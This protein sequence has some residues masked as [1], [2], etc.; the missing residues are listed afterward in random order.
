MSKPW[1]A[2]L[3][4]ALILSAGAAANAAPEAVL[5]ASFDS[6]V[7][8]KG[9]AYAKTH[10]SRAGVAAGVVGQAARLAEKSQL[11]FGLAKGVSLPSG[12]L[13]CWVRPMRDVVYG[14]KFD[15]TLVSI[16]VKKRRRGLILYVNNGRGVSARLARVSVSAPIRLCAGEW[17]AGEWH[18]VALAWTP[19][20]LKLYFDGRLIRE[21]R[22]AVAGLAAPTHLYVGSRGRSPGSRGSEQAIADLDEFAMF[23]KALSHDEIATMADAPLRKGL[24][25]ALDRIRASKADPNAPIV[26]AERSSAVIV[27]PFPPNATAQLGAKELA[28]HLTLATGVKIPLYTE[29]GLA[30]M[31]EAPA[32]LLM[33]GLGRAAREFGASTKGIKPE[34][35]RV[36]T[37]GPHLLLYG[38]DGRG[39]PLAPYTPCGTLHAVYHYL[40]HELGVRWL[41]PGKLG[42]V[43]PRR[44]S[45]AWKKLDVYGRMPFVHRLFRVNLRKR[46]FKEKYRETVLWMRRNHMGLQYRFHY[47]HAFTRWYDKY[48]KDHPEWFARWPDGTTHR[49]G[50]GKSRVKFCTNNEGYIRKMIADADAYFCANPERNS[51]SVCPNDGSSGYCTCAKCTALDI[52]G[53]KTMLKGRIEVVCLADRYA[54]FWNRVARAVAK[55]HPGK[56]IFTYSYNRYNRAPVRTRLE[57]NIVVGF[58]GYG[59]DH[60]E[61]RQTDRGEFVAWAKAGARMW[62]RPNFP[63]SDYFG[64]PFVAARKMAADVKLS[65]ESRMIGIDYAGMSFHW[66]PRAL[67]NYTMARVAWEPKRPFDD[68]LA[69]FTGSAYGPAAPAAKK[70]F[71]ELERASDRVAGPRKTDPHGYRNRLLAQRAYIQG[72]P[73]AVF[74]RALAHLGE[75]EKLLPPGK[76]PERERLNFLRETVNLGRIQ[77]ATLKLGRSLYE[78]GRG[79]NPFIKTLTQRLEFDERHKNDRLISP[80]DLP[81]GVVRPWKIRDAKRYLR[82]VPAAWQRKEHQTYAVPA[83]PFEKDAFTLL[84]LHFDSDLAGLPKETPALKVPAAPNAPSIEPAGRFGSALKLDGDNKDGNGDRKGDADYVQIAN[85]IDT[86]I[87][88]VL[89]QLTVECWIKPDR[90][91]GRQYLLGRGGGCRYNLIVDNGRL[92]LSVQGR[93]PQGKRAWCEAK[94]AEGVIAAGKW[95]H[96]AGVAA[97]NEVRV[98]VDGKLVGK[99]PFD[100]RVSLGGSGSHI[101]ADASMDPRSIRGF[102]G[103]ID[104]FRISDIARY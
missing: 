81:V 31:K 7:P 14:E 87:N 104:E 92:H 63:A 98:Y 64:L 80:T 38:A 94:S 91:A 46:G 74:T 72:F 24:R 36:Q 11:V 44:K 61:R 21:T 103:L 58:A 41:W 93:T 76:S 90:I 25:A 45:L 33:V 60:E 34:E 42:T 26:A 95:Q 88:P 77:A 30:R 66:G 32:H 62:M 71:S 4:A 99:A 83:K 65:A 73:D 48:Y 101:G 57:E 12:T 6:G 47:G 20:S 53:R 82:P 19:Q 22:K 68:I 3:L 37:K 10:A 79:F 16:P 17:S 78:T 67:D 51:F 13:A 50:M 55:A 35:Y 89:R 27:T 86:S 2:S 43:V 100:K 29:L 18:H 5:T 39:S 96:V 9:P 54:K 102:A 8:P 56:Y 23:D 59:Y 70:A 52:P 1:I 85:R 69:D 40:E 49:H 75:G 28:E 97:T 15:R 84:L